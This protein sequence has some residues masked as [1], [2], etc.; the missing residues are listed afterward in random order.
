LNE[1]G[2]DVN[3]GKTGRPD[4]GDKQGNV[5]SEYDPEEAGKSKKATNV[6]PIVPYVNTLDKYSYFSL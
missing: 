4:Q 1:L 3:N 6:Y 5:L 2:I